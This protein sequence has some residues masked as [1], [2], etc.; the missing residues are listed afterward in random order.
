MSTESS[1]MLQS[2]VVVCQVACLYT[3]RRMWHLFHYY[4]KRNN[5]RYASLSCS[6]QMYITKNLVKSAMLLT[7]TPFALLIMYDVLFTGMWRANAIRFLGTVYCANDIVGLYTM[8]NKLPRATLCHHICVTSFAVCNIWIDYNDARNIWRQMAMLA[9]CSTPTY[10]VNT[11]LGARMLISKPQERLIAAVSAFVYSFFICVS[12]L[13][14]IYS[15]ISCLCYGGLTCDMIVY[16]CMVACIFW[17][18]SVLMRYLIRA[19]VS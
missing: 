7:I 2:E 13:Y 17:D 4:M 15:F 5:R 6:R 16:L 14:Q 12:F 3:T 11:Y 19:T 9:A 10:L 8:I 18:D 1:L